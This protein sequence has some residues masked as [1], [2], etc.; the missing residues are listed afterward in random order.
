[1]TAPF[2]L[3]YVLTR[4]RLDPGQAFRMDPELSMHRRFDVPVTMT[5][6]AL[7]HR[8]PR[9]PRRRRDARHRGGTAAP[10]VTFSSSEHLLGDAASR[11]FGRGRR[12]PVHGVD[13]PAASADGATWT[14][15][16]DNGFGLPSL[17]IDVVTDDRHSLPPS[18]AS[19][20]T[21]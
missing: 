7:G 16:L 21:A 17:P 4:L 10:G 14:A 15:T 9:R 19:P 6:L 13:H 18:S 3:A 1:M 11:G 2:P 8:S 12:R 5:V 20:S